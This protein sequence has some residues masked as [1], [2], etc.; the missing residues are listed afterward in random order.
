MKVGRELGSLLRPDRLV[1][2][3]ALHDDLLDTATQLQRSLGGIAVQGVPFTAALDPAGLCSWGADLPVSSPLAAPPGERSWRAWLSSR[4][5]F[6]LSNAFR[7]PAVSPV[8][9]ALDRISLDGVNT[10]NWA[11]TAALLRLATNLSSATDADS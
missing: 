3:F 8:R 5:G 10:V 1:A 2:Y 11:P 7:S 9:F 4:L 6:A